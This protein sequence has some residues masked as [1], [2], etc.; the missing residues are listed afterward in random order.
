[1]VDARP[2]SAI[3]GVMAPGLEAGEYSGPNTDLMQF[4]QSTWESDYRGKVTFP[5]WS[6]DYFDWQFH[7]DLGANRRLCVRDAG[8]LVGV[9]MGSPCRFRL[10][11]AVLHGA[12][13]SWLSVARSHRGRGLA[14]TLDATRMQHEQQHAGDVIVSFRF[15]GSRHSLA[16]RPDRQSPKFQRPIGLWARPLSGSGLRRWNTS[17]AEGWLAWAGTPLTRSIRFPE[18]SACLRPYQHLDLG[19]CLN[20]VT[21]RNDRFA[22]TVDWDET[23]LQHQ[24]G[25]SPVG[26]TLVWERQGVVRGFINFHVLP[27]C[28]RTVEPVAIIDMIEIDQ[29]TPRDQSEFLRRCLQVMQQQGAIVAL[30]LRCGDVSSRTMLLN[31]FT[32]RLRDSHL[33]LQTTAAPIR[34]PSRK[35]VRLLWR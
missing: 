2:T 4:V 35:P 33:V 8:A 28:G 31:G 10:G 7:Q 32:P 20:I 26:Q 14:T 12:H 15:T 17:R 5:L 19:Q 6:A 30:K 24:L 34:L 13:Y 29:L 9:L 23:L 16:E 18:S 3:R 1:M 25:G 22:F 11:A 27:F 21:A